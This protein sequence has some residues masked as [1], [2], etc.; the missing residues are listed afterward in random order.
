MGLISL[1]YVNTI[2]MCILVVLSDYVVLCVPVV[3]LR[4]KYFRFGRGER[5]ID[6]LLLEACLAGTDGRFDSVLGNFSYGIR[7]S[8]LNIES[9]TYLSAI[10]SF[11]TSSV[12]HR[13]FHLI[14]QY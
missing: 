8:G 1:R 7:Y 13:I 12:A 10:R 2:T 5:F 11:L 14:C 4:S 6:H 9:S 3:Y